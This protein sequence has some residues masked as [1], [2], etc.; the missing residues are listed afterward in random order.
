MV[1]KIHKMLLHNRQLKMRKQQRSTSKEG[2]DRFICRQGDG[3][4][5]SLTIEEEMKKKTVYKSF[6][7][8]SKVAVKKL[9]K[10]YW[11][12]ITHNIN[13]MVDTLLCGF[14][15]KTVHIST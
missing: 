4:M 15:N 11:S 7:S 8:F 13:I 10:S 12:I 1:K 9:E 5:I 2:E 3:Q 14:R 6:A